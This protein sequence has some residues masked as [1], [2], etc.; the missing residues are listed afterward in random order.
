CR[1]IRRRVALPLEAPA[2]RRMDARLG[3][4]PGDVGTR[5]GQLAPPLSPPRRR[6]RRGHRPGREDPRRGAPPARAARPGWVTVPQAAAPRRARIR[7]LT[8]PNRS[9]DNFLRGGGSQDDEDAGQPA[10]LSLRGY[11]EGATY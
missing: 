11:P 7:P 6:Q 1:E 2:A 10:L 8:Y 4:D 5:P 9:C 3:A